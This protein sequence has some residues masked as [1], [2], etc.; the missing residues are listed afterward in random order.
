[1]IAV[2]AGWLGA[3]ADSNARGLDFNQTPLAA[4]SRD[5]GLPFADSLSELSILDDLYG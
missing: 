4:A 3:G 1:M 5:P 2:A